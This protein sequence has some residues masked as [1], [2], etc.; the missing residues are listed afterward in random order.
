MQDVLPIL[1]GSSSKSRGLSA[2]CFL[3]LWMGFGL[4][5]SAA[6]I[7]AEWIKVGSGN[8]A[9]PSNWK[10]GVVPV[11]SQTDQYNVVLNLPS[12]TNYTMTM[13]REDME[14]NQLTLGHALHG[15]WSTS[16]KEFHVRTFFRWIGGALSGYGHYHLH[17]DAIFEGN[18]NKPI[19]DTLTI[20]DRA[21]WT[22]GHLSWGG[23]AQVNV[24]AGGLLEIQTG[25]SVGSVSMMGAGEAFNRGTIRMRAPGKTVRFSGY[26]HNPGSIEIEAGELE[27]LARYDGVGEIS[28]QRDVRLMFSGSCQWPNG[29][30]VGAGEMVFSGRPQEVVSGTTFSCFTRINA[31]FSGP[32]NLTLSNAVWEGGWMTGPG[33]LLVPSGGRLTIRNCFLER[34]MTN[35]GEIF[36]PQGAWIH[37]TGNAKHTNGYPGRIHLSS[38]SSFGAR[39]YPAG[40]LVNQGMTMK[41]DEGQ[42]S[43]T[44]ECALQNE[45][46]IGSSAGRLIL[47]HGGQN[48]GRLEA[49]NSGSIEVQGMEFAD[50]SSLVGN[51]L[52][53]L[54]GGTLRGSV[55]TQ[56]DLLATRLDVLST[57]SY[58]FKTLQV[59]GWIR[60]PAFAGAE[61]R[62]G[63]TLSGSLQGG[64]LRS[65]ERAVLSF[66][67]AEITG[68][69]RLELLGESALVQGTMTL[70]GTNSTLL[71]AGSTH[72]LGG[73][74]LFIRSGAAFVNNGNWKMSKRVGSFSAALSDSACSFVA[75]AVSPDQTFEDGVLQISGPVVSMPGQIVAGPGA[76]LVFSDFAVTDASVRLSQSSLEVATNFDSS[77]ASFVLD[78]GEILASS[79][80]LTGSTAFAGQGTIQARLVLQELKLDADPRTN[81]LILNGSL[82]VGGSNAVLRT[83]VS[84]GQ[85]GPAFPFL[86]VHGFVA[87]D[88]RFDLVAAFAPG[89]C[90]LVTGPVVIIEADQPI[91]CVFI[92][93]TNGA[94][95][96]TATNDLRFRLFYG[97]DSPFGANK[98][99]VAEFGT[100]FDLWRMDRFS[101]E[102]LANPLLSG[103][104]ADPDHNGLNNLTEFVLAIDPL[105][106]GADL[107]SVRPGT[108]GYTTIL[109]RRRKDIGGLQATIGIS[110]DLIDWQETVL[111]AGPAWMELHRAF[112][113]ESCYEFFY[114]YHGTPSALFLKIAIGGLY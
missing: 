88:A 47:T 51:G 97:P 53:S 103:P 24:E 76:R 25:G 82:S 21:R 10:D 40:S 98:I 1:T 23:G 50:S 11:R 61:V 94:T 22:E 102:E 35:A 69:A 78:Q 3:G 9:D 8:W 57:N 26:M 38:G 107:P 92:N 99:V 54:L 83:T 39:D 59:A 85:G 33:S 30:Q 41:D 2:W 7:T 48:A 6:D 72:V 62:E 29:S 106:N 65:R 60:F 44:V 42:G 73:S 75:A 74:E 95:L 81:G 100:A 5:I 70:S 101:A 68:G 18:S 108:D 46:V 45:G 89:P 114:R 104:A 16:P 43:S 13:W 93:A 36:L 55:D 52:V 96:V 20:H 80:P 86:K 34:N 77:K 56:L 32:G 28:M 27:F 67:V 4:H 12:P 110:S 109:V 79:R 58:S 105:A 31:D 15:G 14:V 19:D 111:G 17:G 64:L 71:N 112:E 91:S 49:Q 63:L 113:L 66:E 87:V 90:S 37:G 84:L